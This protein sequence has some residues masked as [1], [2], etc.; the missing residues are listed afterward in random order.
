MGGFRR[1]RQPEELMLSVE[2]LWTVEAESVQGWVMSGVVVL[3][4]DRLLG[5]GERYYCTGSYKLRGNIIE[6]EARLFY[7]H[8]P[9]T[10]VFGLPSPDFRVSFKGRCFTELIEGELRRVG[11]AGVKLPFKFIWRAP[12]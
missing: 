12:L 6:G 5:G 7:Y 10:N 11:E 2:G 3:R 1:S 9:M 8:G 4:G